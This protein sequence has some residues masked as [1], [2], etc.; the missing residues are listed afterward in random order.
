M[1]WTQE[2][3][4]EIS[5]RGRMQAHVFEY[6]C[7]C[8][9]TVDHWPPRLIRKPKDFF[10]RGSGRSSSPDSKCMKCIV[11]NKLSR[12]AIHPRS[13]FPLCWCQRAVYLSRGISSRWS[14]LSLFGIHTYCHRNEQ[15]CRGNIKVN[16]GENCMGDTGGTWH[17]R[18]LTRGARRVHIQSAV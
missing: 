4:I 10:H 6:S 9:V 17:S 14:H 13:D 1:H 11:R 8:H 2:E 12:E 7:K 18:S 16:G 5:L 3:C 15:P